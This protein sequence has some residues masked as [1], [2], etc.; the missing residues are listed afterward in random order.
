MRLNKI[1][2]DETLI[3]GDSYIYRKRKRSERALLP[4][5]EQEHPVRRPEAMCH[6]EPLLPCEA[7]VFNATDSKMLRRETSLV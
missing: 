4:H 5:V 6:K 1:K 2:K 3:Q 7:S